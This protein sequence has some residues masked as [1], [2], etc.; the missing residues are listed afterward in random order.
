M[1]KPI[2]RKIN[3]ISKLFNNSINMLV[4]K[5]GINK[6]YFDILHY[7]NKNIA[8]EITQSDICSFLN[9][10]APTISIVL[11]TMEDEGLLIRERSIVDSRKT[12]VRL[13]SYG[14]EKALETKK[15]FLDADK[16]IED[17]LTSEELILFNNYLDKITDNLRSKV[18]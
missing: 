5:S 2:G 14:I 17:C 11:K 8:K 13:S 10:K 16:M 7:L 12:F 9:F 15:I 1:E 3:D 4:Q 6:T 18:K